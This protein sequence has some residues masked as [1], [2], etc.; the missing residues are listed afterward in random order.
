MPTYFVYRS[1]YDSLLGKHVW[2]ADHGTIVDWF[3]RSWDCGGTSADEDEQDLRAVAWLRDELGTCPYG[4]S[5]IFTAA[6]RERLPPPSSEEELFASLR[7]HLYVEGDKQSRLLCQP[8]AFQVYT[9]DDNL[10]VAYYFFDQTFLAEHSSLTAFL[11]RSNWRLPTEHGSGSFEHAFSIRPL[12]T[13]VDG[14][15]GT[16][17]VVTRECDKLEFETLAERPPVFLP[18][19]RLPRL[20]SFLRASR[21][22]ED[23]PPELVLLWSQLPEPGELSD[24]DLRDSLNRVCMFGGQVYAY[25]DEVRQLPKGHARRYL[26]GS[27]GTRSSCR[28]GGCAAWARRSTWPS[29]AG[30]SRTLRSGPRA[31]T[32]ITS[33]TCSTTCGP[34]ATQTRRRAC[35]GSRPAGTCFRPIAG[36]EEGSRERLTPSTAASLPGRTPGAC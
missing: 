31:A 1:P 19:V 21:P 6:G 32:S 14:E 4:L 5:S 35:C 28:T 36:R 33:G 25:V 17:L 10:D 8:A 23:W 30:A 22:T 9:D 18:G 26:W 7:E 3:R 34:P 20:T 11:L 27:C 15:G 12:D 16:F 24:D 2:R 13:G 29:S